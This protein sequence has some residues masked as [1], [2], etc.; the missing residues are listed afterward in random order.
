MFSIEER[1]YD[2][3]GCFRYGKEHTLKE[4]CRQ[5]GIHPKTYKSWE[6]QGLVPKVQRHLQSGYR[7][8]T[9]EDIA[10]LKEFVTQR[11]QN[12]KS[13]LQVT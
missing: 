11:K 5:V 2:E 10:W 1:L 9:D 6:K 3:E 4:T 12:P 8:F 13:R 7:I